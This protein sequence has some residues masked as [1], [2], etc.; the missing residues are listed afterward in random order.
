M[1]NY[2]AD[3]LAGG[4]PAEVSALVQRR[5]IHFTIRARE[6]IHSLLDHHQWV[7]RTPDCWSGTYS[8]D[9]NCCVAK[10]ANEPGCDFNSN[11]ELA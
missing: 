7:H 2:I 3:K 10:A 1:G 6:A 5:A 9:S 4:E 11:A 8:R